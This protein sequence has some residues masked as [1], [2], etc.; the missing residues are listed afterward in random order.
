MVFDDESLDFLNNHLS[1]KS[2][3]DRATHPKTVCHRDE[4][5]KFQKGRR[6][7]QPWTNPN[8]F[9]PA[10]AQE[11]SQ[12]FLTFE[13]LLHSRLQEIELT[14]HFFSLGFY[15]GGDLKW[16]VLDLRPKTSTIFLGD[17]KP[18]GL[19]IKKPL[20]LFIAAHIRDKRL[21][22]IRQN[23][24]LG[25]VLDLEFSNQARIQMILI[26]SQLNILAFHDQKTVAFEK[27]RELK[28]QIAM[29]DQTLRSPQ[30]IF[31][32]W[33]A[34][35]KAIAKP[36]VAEDKNARAIAKV[37][38][39]LDKKTSQPFR[40]LGQFLVEHQTLDVP[41][42]L[43]SFID[44]TKTLSENIQNVFFKAKQVEQ[45]LERTQ[46]RL[47]ELLVNKPVEQKKILKSA[48]NFKARTLHMDDQ[49]ELRVGKSAKDNL[50]LLRQARSWD[51]WIHLK[52]VPSSH[53]ILFRSKNRTITDKEF[54]TAAMFLLKNMNKKYDRVEVLIAE[55]RFV[56]PI[57]GDKLGRVTHHN[58]RTLLVPSDF[59]S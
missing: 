9:K 39:E 46:S 27:P 3:T 17:Q 13:P 47:K 38:A 30:D 26:P 18:K 42:H 50:T 59:T 7:F 25:R 34:A 12:I 4:P 28:P 57:K 19:A 44:K 21:L 8:M 35:Q 52:D 48:Q 11:L 33:K 40:E 51:Y 20:T 5:C 54:F 16:I 56:R 32:E 22:S 24:E 58:A 31:N 36:Q 10:N 23:E 29:P 41:L 49:L 6:R 1:P 37:R 15:G 53:A 14:Q 45:K 55:C 2:Q 43:Q